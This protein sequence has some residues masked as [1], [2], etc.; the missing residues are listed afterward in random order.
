MTPI[1]TRQNIF[2]KFRKII[3]FYEIILQG[4]SADSI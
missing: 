3:V 1:L 4:Q 2:V